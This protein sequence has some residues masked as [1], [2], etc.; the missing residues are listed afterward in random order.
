[1]FQTMTGP[2]LK[3]IRKNLGLSVIQMGRAIGYGG[4]DRTVNVQIR[5]YENN[6]RDIPEWIARLALMFAKHGVPRQFLK[7]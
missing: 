6:T 1:M 7:A 4:S 5:R 2:D 3:A